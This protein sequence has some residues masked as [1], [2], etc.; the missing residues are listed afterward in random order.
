MDAYE[1]LQSQSQVS[2]APH[3]GMSPAAILRRLMPGEVLV[4]RTRAEETP[5]SHIFEKNQ[6]L[7]LE[8]FLSAFNGYIQSCWT[9][10]R[11]LRSE[12]ESLS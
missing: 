7:E 2:R 1:F 5:Q 12:F 11:H 8:T 6:R 3:E 10:P 4:V 9:M